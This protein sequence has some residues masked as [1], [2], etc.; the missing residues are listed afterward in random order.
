MPLVERAR[1]HPRPFHGPYLR[2][3]PVA[4]P[5][6]GAGLLQHAAGLQL[7]DAALHQGVGQQRL[8]GLKGHGGQLELRLGEGDR[9]AVQAVAVTSACSRGIA[10]APS[11]G[12]GSTTSTRAQ[13]S[14]PQAR[15]GRRATGK[16]RRFS[17]G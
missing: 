10:P 8:P 5:S 12:A 15:S 9:V 2:R 14:A 7:V 1:S 3:R 4:H 13:A 17:S 11:A 16:P 6:G